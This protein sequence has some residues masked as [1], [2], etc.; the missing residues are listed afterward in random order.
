VAD[1]GI[2]I[3]PE[4]KKR[5]FTHFFRGQHHLVR[6]HKGTGLGLAIARSIVE[7]H[8]GE[9]SVESEVGKGSTFHFT[10]PQAPEEHA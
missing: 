7:A 2:G 8:G 4:D 10:I 1:T 6:S 3:P 9:I 5:L